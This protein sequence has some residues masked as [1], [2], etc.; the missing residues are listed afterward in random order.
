MNLTFRLIVALVL[1]TAAGCAARTASP[2]VLA[3][4]AQ[5]EPVP[6]CPTPRPSQVQPPPDSPTLF[7]SL[8]LCLPTQGNVSEIAMSTYLY[9]MGSDEFV[10]WPAQ[11]RWTP[12]DDTIKRMLYED[13]RALMETGFLTDLKIEILDDP[14]PNGVEGKRVVFLMAERPLAERE[15]LRRRNLTR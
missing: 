8:Q 14:Y 9:Y 5:G 2:T 1:T 13:S 6:G 7:T 10:S 12:F 4:A 15:A 3:E 11:E